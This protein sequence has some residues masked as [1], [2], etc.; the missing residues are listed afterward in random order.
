MLEVLRNELKKAELFI[1]MSL[2]S[3]ANTS[4]EF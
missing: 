4:T 1:G 3:I 2:I